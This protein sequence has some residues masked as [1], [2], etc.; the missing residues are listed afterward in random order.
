MIF[1]KRRRLIFWLLKAYLK[2]WR[3]TIFISFLIGIIG[4]FVI[5]YGVNYFIPLLPFVNEQ[6]IGI[7]GAYT[8]DDLPSTIVSKVSSGLTKLDDHY[9]VLPNV[10]S[11]W[12]IRD[13]GKTYVF[14]LKDNIFF[15]D[16]TKLTS[17]TF[18]YKFTDALIQTPNKLTIV[19]RLKSKYSPFLVTMSRPIFKKGFIGIGDYKVQSINLNGNF[20]QSITLRSVK[21]QSNVL[22][23]QF[24]PTQEALKTAFALGE[25]NSAY[26]LTDVDYKDTSFANFPNVI[27]SKNLND[28]KLVTIFY[29]T[30]DKDLSDKRLREALGYAVPDNFYLGQRNYG[31]FSPNSWVSDKGLVTY[32]QDFEH[33]NLLLKQSDSFK[34][35]KKLKFEMK[36]YPKY[37]TLANKIKSEWEK[38]GIFV[39][40]K[41]VEAFPDSF[42]IFLGD[43][44]I[45]RDPDQYL[46][47]HSGQ[48]ENITGYKNLRIDKLLEDGRQIIDKNERK[49]IYTDFQKYFLDDPPATF[50]LFPYSYNVTRK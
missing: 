9:N 15:N 1:L 35:K 43:Y 23:Y 19:F 26:N 44:I 38:I 40:I 33:A 28:Q 4:F 11:S 7:E 47:W 22:V 42:Q 41:V 34:N 14:Y 39:D 49:K 31:P 29:N 8:V 46:L 17:D 5:R 37:L 13:E 30:L 24:Y 21:K 6:R 18:N 25:I 27:V 16:K 36:T 20:V 32:N 12:E 3:K 10:A 2:R 48:I 45:P 50:V